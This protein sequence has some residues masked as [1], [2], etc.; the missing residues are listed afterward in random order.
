MSLDG[1]VTA[2]NDDSTAGAIVVGR[3]MFDKGTTT[4]TF[5]TDGIGSAI[6][7][8]SA[9]AG[10]KNVTIAG[11]ASTA[12]QAL[13]AGLVDELRIHVAPV[14]L[15]AGTRL[16]DHLGYGRTVLEQTRVLESPFAAHLRLRVPRSS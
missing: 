6:E 1:F 12:Q 7:Q 15:G 11:G 14:L 4:F 8:A 10:G 5:V 3:R 9:A 2:P 13:N 16:F